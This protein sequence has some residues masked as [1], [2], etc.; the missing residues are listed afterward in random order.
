M[1]EGDEKEKSQREEEEKNEK[2]KA[3][4]EE[5]L[6]K[7]E[8]KTSKKDREAMEKDVIQ[9]LDNKIFSL[10]SLYISLRNC[11]NVIEILLNYRG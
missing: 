11:W 4:K 6:E 8:A 2:E 1:R 7:E 5:K 3:D 9:C 10:F